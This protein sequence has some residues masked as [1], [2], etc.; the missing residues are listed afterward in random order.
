MMTLPPLNDLYK[1]A[2]FVAAE[3]AI[4]VVLLVAARFVVGVIARRLATAP[5]FSKYGAAVNTIQGNV[6]TAI[7][8]FGFLSILCIVALNGFLIFK[9]KDIPSETLALA[10]K[11][12][13]AS[14]TNLLV[15]IL[16]IAGIAIA[17]AFLVR[18]I[19]KGLAKAQAWVNAHDRIKGNDESIEVFVRSLDRIQ[20]NAIWL[21][22]LILSAGILSPQPVHR[23]R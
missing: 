15:G 18:A 13:P 23:R 22:M 10:A 9:G 11:L 20:R 21:A 4:P 5:K 2:L 1:P 12:Q 3:I 17:A 8:V 14:W 16:K 19:R 7:L 6:R